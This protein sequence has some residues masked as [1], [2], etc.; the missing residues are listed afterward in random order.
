L[1]KAFSITLLALFIFQF[2]GYYFVYMGLRYQAKSEMVTRLDSRD[3]STDETIT[4]K[5]PFALPYWMDSKNYE[6][7]NGEFEYQGDFYKLVEQKL[8]K[9][10]LYV[11]CIKDASEKRL[12]N[13]M[14]DYVKLSNDLPSSSQQALKLLGSLMKDFVKSVQIEMTLSQGWSQECSFAEPFFNLI[15]LA[16]PVSSPPPEFIG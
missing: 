13:A 11:V 7:V 10:T 15:T 2:I 5:I 1:K 12:F 6:R 14:S 8:E 3:Y 16:S 9:D 4:L